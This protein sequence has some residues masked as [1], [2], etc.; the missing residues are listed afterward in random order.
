[1][2]ALY[3]RARVLE[4]KSLYRVALA[5]YQR[6]LELGGGELNGNQAKVER[7]IP[8]LREKL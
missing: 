6:F 1:M 8:D 7:T 2:D 4:D 3:S 5:D